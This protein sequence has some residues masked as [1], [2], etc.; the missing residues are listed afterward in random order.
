ME[1]FRSSRLLFSILCDYRFDHPAG[2]PA[3][4]NPEGL[5]GPRRSQVRVEQLSQ[6]LPAL[7]GVA[8]EVSQ[9]Q[10]SGG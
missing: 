6:Y 10:Q 4:Q 1:H 9:L 3:G 2:L 8:A 7:L 5:V